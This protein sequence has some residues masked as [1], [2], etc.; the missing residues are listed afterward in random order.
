MKY[1]LWRLGIVLTF[2]QFK[3]L[4]YL[5]TYLIDKTELKDKSDKTIWV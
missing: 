4:N 5:G 1:Y 3:S 2:T